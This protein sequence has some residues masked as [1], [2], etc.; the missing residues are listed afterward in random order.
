MFLFDSFEVEV[1]L[2]IIQY[3]DFR[4]TITLFNVYDGLNVPQFPSFLNILKAFPLAE[5]VI[6]SLGIQINTCQS[7]VLQIPC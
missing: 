4:D 7:L 3:P 2:G 5:Q 1:C 6:G